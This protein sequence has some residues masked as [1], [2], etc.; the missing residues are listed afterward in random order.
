MIIEVDQ[1]EGTTPLQ[2]EQTIDGADVSLRSIYAPANL[3]I[4]VVADETNL[5]REE[6]VRLADLHGLMTRHRRTDLDPSAIHIHVLVVTEDHDEPDDLGL[7]FDFGAQDA[8]DVPREAFAVFDSVHRDSGGSIERELLLTTAHEL[9]HCF[10]L[11][12]QDWDGTGFR[13]GSTIEGYSSAAT[14]RWRLSE[15]SL[16]HFAKHDPRLVMPGADGRPFGDETKEHLD[17]HQMIPGGSYNVVDL[18]QLTAAARRAGMNHDQAVRA[19][20]TWQAAGAPVPPTPL[21]LT[22]WSQQTSYEVGEPIE[23]TAR[24]LN[25]G[26]EAAQVVTLIEPEYGFLNIAIRRLEDAGERWEPFQPAVLRNG[27]ARLRIEPLA[28]GAAL[29]GQARVFFGSSGWN[30][31]RP[32]TYEVVADF[33][34]G[35]LG[36]GARLV[37]QPLRLVVTAPEA[38]P[39]AAARRILSTADQTRLGTEQ[40]LYLLFQGGSHL[41]E[42]ATKIRQLVQ[43]VPTAAQAPAANLALARAALEPAI[44]PAGLAK[45]AP[46]LDA[47]TRYFQAV[48]VS[49]VSPWAVSHVSSALEAELQKQGRPAAIEG[50]VRESNEAVREMD[51][52]AVDRRKLEQVQRDGRRTHRIESDVRDRVRPP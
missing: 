40:G 12:H 37:S 7:M 47:A 16:L 4:Q 13:E 50:K 44:D 45:P 3:A 32:G 5:P 49:R 14:V 42:G 35:D 46:S 38:G 15:K 23:L 33:P 17:F 25:R 24:L 2:L 34:A 21:E 18:A 52:D 41:R 48:D 11:H 36:T 6:T 20:L 51:L 1:M 43:E 9:A 8:N 28:P 30:F 26:N 31:E 19:A 27:R 22:L 39:G 29:H 10:N